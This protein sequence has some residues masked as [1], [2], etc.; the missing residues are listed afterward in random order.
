[1]RIGGTW[2]WLR[3]MVSDKLLYSSTVPFTTVI[4]SEEFVQ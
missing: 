1:M 4:V 2:N 3:I